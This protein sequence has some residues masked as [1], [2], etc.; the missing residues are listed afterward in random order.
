M[1]V[2]WSE[3]E[4]LL[5]VLVVASIFRTCHLHPHVSQADVSLLRAPLGSLPGRSCQNILITLDSLDAP[6]L[7]MDVS[8]PA[9]TEA[10]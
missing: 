8:R 5:E 3:A 4:S 2:S 7:I 9:S 1:Q 6:A 10:D